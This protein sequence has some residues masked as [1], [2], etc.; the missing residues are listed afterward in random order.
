MPLEAGPPWRLA[1][2]PKRASKREFPSP[3]RHR[4]NVVQWPGGRRFIKD[5]DKVY[6]DNEGTLL[7][8]VPCEKLME[9]YF[10]RVDSGDNSQGKV[11]DIQF[12]AKLSCDG[13][14]YKIDVMPGS[15]RLLFIGSEKEAKKLH[16]LMK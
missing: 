6:I 14:E 12:G 2:Q 5:N 1:T 7:D 15:G 8:Y 11:F 4:E 16:R 3:L 9:I 10:S 13:N